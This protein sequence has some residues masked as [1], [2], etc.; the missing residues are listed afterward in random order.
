MAKG[1]FPQG[2]SSEQIVTVAN[3]TVMFGDML[4]EL[5]K[6]KMCVNDISDLDDV[7]DEDIE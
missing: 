4:K 3:L 1:K 6:I 2:D 5:K 7:T